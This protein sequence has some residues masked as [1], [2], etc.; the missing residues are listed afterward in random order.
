MLL[1]PE[2][3]RLAVVGAGPE[4]QEVLA[5]QFPGVQDRVRLIAATPEVSSYYLAA[6]VYVHPTLQDSFGMAPLEAMAHG[7]PVILS[8]AAY[9]GFA[10]YVTHEQNGW[11]LSDPQ[12]PE[13]IATA[14]R[15]LGLDAEVR[16]RL[17]AQATKL[18]A[19]FSWAAIAE[20]YEALYAKS[21]ASRE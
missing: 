20:R 17:I 18:V 21:L 12:D 14:L 13:Q 15:V 6:D 3:F 19:D 16:T 8:G 1:L 9:C 4:V 10:Q 11:V 7:L 2:T 5:V